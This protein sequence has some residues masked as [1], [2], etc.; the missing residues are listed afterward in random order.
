MRRI[1]CVYIYLTSI[2]TVVWAQKTQYSL[3]GKIADAVTGESVVG[4]TIVIGD[5]ELWAVSDNEGNFIIPSVDK[6]VITMMIYN[7]KSGMYQKDLM[8]STE[9]L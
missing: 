9:V 6:S 8:V 2:L 7:C 3:E 1:L 5:M 4:A